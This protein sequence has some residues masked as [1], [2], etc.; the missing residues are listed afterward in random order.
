[1]AKI[2]AGKRVYLDLPLKFLLRVKF[3]SRTTTQKRRS[4]QEVPDM[5]LTRTGTTYMDAPRSK[6]KKKAETAHKSGKKRKCGAQDLGFVL[7]PRM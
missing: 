1:M 5:H 6:A 3:T 7:F 2:P 4:T